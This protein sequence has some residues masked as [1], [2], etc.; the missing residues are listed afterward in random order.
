MNKLKEIKEKLRKA[1]ELPVVVPLSLESSRPVQT[2]EFNMT[3]LEW[4]VSYCEGLERALEAAKM[5]IAKTGKLPPLGANLSDSIK[6]RSK[7]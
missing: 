4:L 5:A 3:D 7:T 2:V 6:M 1:R